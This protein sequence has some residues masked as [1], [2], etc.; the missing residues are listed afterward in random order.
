MPTGRRGRGGR[1]HR[2]A[3]ELTD[4]P[5]LIGK[6]TLIVRRFARARARLVPD[7]AS[8]R[9]HARRRSS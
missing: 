9:A 8:G 4:D 3:R 1:A 7:E 5:F 2:T 6:N